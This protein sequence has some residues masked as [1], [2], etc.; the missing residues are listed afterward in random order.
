MCEM[1][2][3]TCQNLTQINW[4]L[5]VFFVWNKQKSQHPYFNSQSP[6]TNYA[7]IKTQQPGTMLKVKRSLIQLK[8]ENVYCKKRTFMKMILWHLCTVKRVKRPC[9][10]HGIERECR[11]PGLITK[12]ELRG[13]FEWEGVCLVAYIKHTL[14]LLRNCY[15][16]SVSM[17][18]V[19]YICSNWL[20]E[21][22]KNR[23]ALYHQTINWLVS[24]VES[25]NQGARIKEHF[26]DNVKL[27]WLLR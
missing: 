14:H 18:S 3:S 25:R 10:R 23:V 12:W 22:L 7:N 16:I 9:W 26:D 17:S 5:L 11:P 8:A 13:T 21:R 20:T 4:S 19:Q 15:V 2:Y 6:W 24:C 27:V 1:W